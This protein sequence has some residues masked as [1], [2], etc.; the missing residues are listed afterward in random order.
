MKAINKLR[1]ILCA[2]SDKIK[3]D[4]MELRFGTLCEFT[5]EWGKEIWKYIEHCEYNG[6]FYMTDKMQDWVLPEDN[7]K[8]IWNPIQ[9]RHLRMYLDIKTTLTYKISDDGKFFIDNTFIGLIDNTK[10]FHLQDEELL[11][12]IVDFL[13]S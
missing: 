1:D 8:I 5:L 13:E 6:Y 4:L 3:D 2:G 11:Q 10:D 9:E 7:V 12:S